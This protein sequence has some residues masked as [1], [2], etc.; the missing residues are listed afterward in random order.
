LPAIRGVSGRVSMRMVRLIAALAL[1]LGMAA[2][3]NA[4]LPAAT[5]P[6]STLSSGASIAATPTPRPTASPK[7][8][9]SILPAN[10]GTTE[11]HTFP[12]GQDWLARLATTLGIELR[13]LKVAYASDHGAAFVQMYAMR[14]AG[15]DAA[16]LLAAL[17]AVAYPTGEADV[18]SMMIAGRN[19]TVINQPETAN[20]LGTFYAFA[21]GDTLIVAEA[22][23]EP[24]V[25][26]AFQALPGG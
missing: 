23:A 10:I 12:V 18:T 17:Q 7:A 26:R 24:V 5:A 1:T 20:R 3:A 13:D 15:L 14:A 2:C 4:G 8:L 11:L 22:F 21:M 25:E 19:V 9:Q 16:R 6:L